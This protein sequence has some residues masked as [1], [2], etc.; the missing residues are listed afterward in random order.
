MKRYSFL[1]LTVLMVLLTSLSALGAVE[2]L[3]PY[4]TEMPQGKWGGTLI[5]SMI[6]DPNTL[7]PVLSGDSASEE[8]FEARIFESLAMVNPETGLYEPALARSWETSEDGLSWTFHLRRGVQWTDGVEFTADDV[9]FTYDVTFD[10]NVASPSR[11]GLFIGGEPIKYE[12]LDKYTVRFTT[13]KP[14]AP[15]LSNL[16]YIVPKHKLYDAWQA[17][18]FN[19]TWGVDMDPTDLVGTGPLTLAQYRPAQRVVY[20][21]NSNYWKK[22]PNGQSLP[23]IT[24]WVNE[25]VPDVDTALLKFQNGKTHIVGIPPQDVAR[26]KAGEQ[27]GNY[28]VHQAGTSFT[29]T[30]IAF[31]MN[32]RN[33]DFQ[34]HPWKNQWFRNIH[35]RRALNHATD[36]T[37]IGEQVY[38]G[39]AVP[40][41]S[42][43][44]A[45]N[46][47]WVH[48]GVRKYP[49]DLEKAREELKLGGFT[50]NQDGQLIG[51]DGHLVEINLLT[52]ETSNNWVDMMNILASDYQKLG[53]KVNA[54]GVA[55]SNLITR[56]TN[57]YEW[58]MIIVGWG[59]SGTELYGGHTMWLSSALYHMWNPKLEEPEFAWEARVDQLWEEA[60]TT[61]DIEERKAL[62]N[63]WQDIYAEN[64]PLLYAVNIMTHQAVTDKLK[65]IRPNSLGGDLYNGSI[66]WDY[67]NLYF[68]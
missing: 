13:P 60:A 19:E 68:E 8:V 31:N 30:L 20:L 53:L 67:A 66:T 52:T 33:P 1:F 62:Y 32:P 18:K 14:F 61:L 7:N 42:P 35:F 5:T 24:R 17:G 6:S 44:N 46:K 55:F 40:Q 49:F 41:W 21:R 37:T 3:D 10:E 58:D 65:N 38:A 11:E 25:I 4:H 36:R 22:A 64:L 9:I 51:P 48:H 56:L 28:T 50:W 63:E 2:L 15:F 12:K 39:M 34:Q 16:L 47:F 45:A 27:A 29:S 43:V 57:S 26:I 23:Y 59:G 54:T